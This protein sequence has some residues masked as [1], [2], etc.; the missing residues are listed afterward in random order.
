MSH[1]PGASSGLVLAVLQLAVTAAQHLA[2]QHVPPTHF[3][4]HLA[5]IK[6]ALVLFCQV[7]QASCGRLEKN[8]A[9]AATR[10]AA[11]RSTVAVMMVDTGEWG[12]EELRKR[13]GNA[14][15]ELVPELMIFRFG[16]ASP[17]TGRRDADAVYENLSALS[18][19]RR[20]AKRDTRAANAPDDDETPPDWMLDQPA[21]RVLSLTSA[22]FHEA[23]GSFPLLLVLFYSAERHTVHTNF[24]HGNFSAAAVVLHQQR[25]NARFAKMEVRRDWPEGVASAR[26]P[27]TPHEHAPV[28]QCPCKRAQRDDCPVPQASEHGFLARVPSDKELLP[29]ARRPPVSSAR[30]ACSQ[31]PSV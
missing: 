2:L 14:N 28:T 3:E 15:A 19:G 16:Q 24:L 6:L 4:P 9:E 25:I 27:E 22:N 20:P 31:L 7:S 21:D 11:E 17:Y 26:T 8:L 29:S 13:Y 23:V 1:L 30:L 10:L 5:P 18:S 12:G